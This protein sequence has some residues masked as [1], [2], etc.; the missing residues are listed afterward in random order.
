[1]ASLQVSA[2]FGDVELTKALLSEG[3]NV[4]ACFEPL[5]SPLYIAATH[6]FLSIAEV[7][8]SKGADVNYYAQSEERWVLFST[9]QQVY[10]NDGHSHQCVCGTEPAHAELL[11]IAK[12]LLESGAHPDAAIPPGI[13]PLYLSIAKGDVQVVKLLPEHKADIRGLEGS[14]FTPLHLCL[15]VGGSTEL[16]EELLKA[17]ADVNISNDNGITPLFRAVNDGSEEI[18]RLLLPANPDFTTTDPDRNTLI[19]AAV[20]GKNDNIL[21]TLLEKV[22]VHQK[23]DSDQSQVG[24]HTTNKAGETPLHVA[25]ERG[26]VPLAKTLLMHGANIEARDNASVIPLV[27]AMLRER[28]EMVEF[29]ISQGANCGTVREFRFLKSMRN[30]NRTAVIH[31]GQDDHSGTIKLQG[32]DGENWEEYTSK[33]S[34]GSTAT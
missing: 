19:H 32:P 12:L 26:C 31:M 22:Q 28:D 33:Y 13:S 16:V 20:R 15:Q 11:A 24:V 14:G 2:L 8:I 10:N 7:L 6:G 18:F 1:M 30:V 5:G 17:G 34:I 23:L 4:N 27:E 9:L 21:S 25:A 29:L 3:H